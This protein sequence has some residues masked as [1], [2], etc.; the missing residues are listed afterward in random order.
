MKIV[1]TGGLGHIGSALIR[2][3]P[4]SF[5]NPE[6]VIIDDLSTQRYC[7]LFNLPAGA[8]YTFVEAD[9]TRVDLDSQLQGAGALVHLAAVTDATSSFDRAE[10]VEEV[11]ARGL[12][13]IAS[14]CREHH[15]PLIFISTTSVYGSQASRVD[16]DCRE[17]LPQSPYAHSKLRAEEFLLR[18][19]T[20]RNLACIVFRF[21]TI[22]GVSEGMRFHTAVNKFCWQAR[23]GEPITVWRTAMHQYRPYLDLTDAVA[24]VGFAIKQRLYDRRIYNLVTAN[25]S[26]AQIIDAIRPHVPS[27]EVKL[28]ESPVM[29]QLSYEVAADRIQERGFRFRG[30]IERS[31]EDTLRLLSGMSPREQ[32]H[33]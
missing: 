21:G 19:E 28:V 20:M 23:W 16:E 10:R 17:L 31:I 8:R 25:R 2:F 13:R 27:L 14:A 3:L 24:A 9:I 33:A 6:I 15:V 1:V 22:C 11:N 7:S 26:V 5:E 32:L 30:S 4:A 12:E 29:N 18:H